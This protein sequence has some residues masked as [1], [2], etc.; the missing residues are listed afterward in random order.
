[1]M[2]SKLNTH[3][4]FLLSSAYFTI[5]NTHDNDDGD[6]DGDAS[7]VDSDSDVMLQMIVM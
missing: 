5:C 3:T 6:G 2:R 7:D 4:G 1:M